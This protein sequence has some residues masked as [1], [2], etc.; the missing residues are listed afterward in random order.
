MLN[1]EF[2]PLI[3]KY[4]FRNTKVDY[5]KNLQEIRSVAERVVEWDRKNIRTYDPRWISLHGIDAFLENQVAFE[6]RSRWAGIDE[7]TRVDYLN[8]FDEAAEEMQRMDANNDGAVSEAEVEADNQRERAK[9][10]A[11]IKRQISETKFGE[12]ETPDRRTRPAE[13]ARQ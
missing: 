8:G 12:I 4:A 2:G 9:M 11:E 13:S 1:S 10:D 7:Q 6:P 3:N 5:K